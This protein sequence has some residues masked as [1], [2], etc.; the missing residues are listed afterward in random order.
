MSVRGPPNQPKG[1]CITR[2][3]AFQQYMNMHLQRAS[4]SRSPAASCD[5]H[6]RSAYAL[7]GGSGQRNEECAV[8]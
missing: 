6:A 1:R 3:V 7:Q 2:H 5:G 4:F 8:K